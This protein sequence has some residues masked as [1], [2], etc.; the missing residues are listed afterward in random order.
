MKI[1]SL[2]IA[3]FG[4]FSNQTFHFSDDG[5]QL[6]YGLNESGKTTLKAFIESMLFGFSKSHMYKPKHGSFYG[7]SLT[8]FDE[9]LGVIH[10]E[11]TSD[12]GGQA[13][14]FFAKW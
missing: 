10:I 1:R 12:H 7:G 9:E 8:C 5:F 11:R 3:N 14:V 4:K 2:H 6:V 13:Q